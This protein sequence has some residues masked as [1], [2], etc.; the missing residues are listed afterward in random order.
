MHLRR[1]SWVATPLLLALSL[2]AAPARAQTM[3]LQS[4]GAIMEH[5]SGSPVTAWT[6]LADRLGAGTVNWRTLAIMHMAMHDALNAARQRYARVL[7]RA[8][9]EPTAPAN[10]EVAMAT[11]AY[12]VLISRHGEQA[13]QLGDPLYRRALSQAPRGPATE[14]GRALGIAIARQALDRYRPT[15]GMPSSFPASDRPGEWRPTPPFFR[16]ALMADQGPFL[17]A[18][19]EELRGPPPPPFASRSYLTVVDEVHRMGEDRSTSRS[20]A[21]TAAALFWGRQTSQRGYVH[22]AVDLLAEYPLPGGLW[23]EARVMALTT[24][25]MADSYLIVWDMKRHFRYLRPIVAIQEGAGGAFADP[26]WNP[27]LPTPPHPEYP[28]GH[29]ADCATGSTLL[30]GLFGARL[31]QVTYTAVD[32][33]EQPSRSFPSLAAAAQECAD[34]RLWAGA[35]FRTANEEG[36]RVGRL[37]AER[38]LAFLPL[39]TR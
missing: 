31:T 1:L 4:E 14:A 10:P 36:L 19:A 34:S 21:Q 22:L 35:H 24:I 33:P 2:S 20:R 16:S 32:I 5:P 18:S 39:I 27:L 28:S 30:Q 8:P 15:E 3:G 23:D 26:G 25:A 37:I 9:G 7:P 13:A 6:L 12:Q 11:A 29:A 38:A 17:F